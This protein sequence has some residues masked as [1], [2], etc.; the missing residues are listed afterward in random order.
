MKSFFIQ[1]SLHQKTHHGACFLRSLQ[2][3][4]PIQGFSSPW[5]FQLRILIAIRGVVSTQFVCL[6]KFCLTPHCLKPI[7]ILV[8]NFSS[9]LL[10]CKMVCIV[11][12]IMALQSKKVAED[13]Q[14]LILEFD[15][16]VFSI[17]TQ[18]ITT[19]TKWLCDR[20][21]NLNQH[22]QVLFIVTSSFF[23]FLH[24]PL[25]NSNL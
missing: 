23:K 9:L 14:S 18:N 15:Q 2:R 25:S 16:S 12:Q 1:S 10:C 17:S 19:M 3:F 11:A 21:S 8:H 5:Q 20:E 4:Q 13:R 6:C 7:T 22:K 24:N